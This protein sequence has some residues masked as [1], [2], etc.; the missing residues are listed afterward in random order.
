M[1]IAMKILAF[2]H[3]CIVTFEEFDQFSGSPIPM[4]LKG[5]AAAPVW[6]Y[7]SLGIVANIGTFVAGVIGTT[8]NSIQN[9]SQK[10]FY[11]MAG[12]A[13][14][15]VV[16]VGV[17]RVLNRVAP[18]SV[19]KRW[20]NF[21]IPAC[22]AAGAVAG[23]LIEFFRFRECDD[24]PSAQ[25]RY[26]HPGHVYYSVPNGERVSGA[27]AKDHV[28]IGAVP[29]AEGT[30]SFGNASVA[31][32]NGLMNGAYEACLISDGRVV[33]SIMRNQFAPLVDKNPTIFDSAEFVAVGN[34]G[35]KFEFLGDCLV[36]KR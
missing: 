7:D 9:E 13:A 6:S 19:A 20:F 15:G 24:L 10:S 14:G 33:S 35:L 23:S 31:V 16:G 12:F 28:C 11:G 18:S 34:G 1:M 5:G 21:G 27:F 29:H 32:Q 22:M 4:Q 26:E 8:L 17:Q 30:L 2:S 3:E 25:R 36:A